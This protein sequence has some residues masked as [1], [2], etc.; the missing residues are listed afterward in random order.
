MEINISVLSETNKYD[1]YLNCFSY[2]ARRSSETGNFDL[3][4][5]VDKAGIVFLV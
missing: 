3:F 5:A 1:I 4:K 2:A